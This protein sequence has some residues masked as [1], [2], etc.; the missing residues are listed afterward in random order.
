[1]AGHVQMGQGLR[2]KMTL[3]QMT[4]MQRPHISTAS[5]IFHAGCL[6]SRGLHGVPPTARM[7]SELWCLP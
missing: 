7:R 6:R 5:H 1:M 3:L 4:V 2:V